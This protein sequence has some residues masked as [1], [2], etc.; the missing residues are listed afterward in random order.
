MSFFPLHILFLSSSSFMPYRYIVLLYNLSLFPLCIIGVFSSFL[1]SS[2]G[3]PSTF[4]PLHFLLLILS[5]FLLRFLSAYIFCFLDFITQ[6]L[7]L[8]YIL[9]IL[10]SVLIS[11]FHFL[12]FLFPAR[13]SHQSLPSVSPSLLSCQRLTSNQLTAS[14]A[15][16]FLPH[17]HTLMSLPI[18]TSF[19]LLPPLPHS[20]HHT[21]PPHRLLEVVPITLKLTC[22]HSH[23]STLPQAH[24]STPS[25][26]STFQPASTLITLHPS[27]SILGLSLTLRLIHTH[28]LPLFT[29]SRGIVSTAHP[30]PHHLR[31][32]PY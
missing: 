8:R 13:S 17:P 9:H 16:F 24:V 28:T 20:N 32:Y 27:L 29:T 2:H 31:P 4:F 30:Y 15:H 26:S 25:Y 12:C 7:P 22:T 14:L 3:L 19:R 11:L 21:L 23:Y 6:R 10:L 1:F 5:C 18:L